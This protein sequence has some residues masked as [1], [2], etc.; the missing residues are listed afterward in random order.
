MIV[1]AIEAARDS[2]LFDR[3]VVS[4]DDEEIARVAEDCGAEAPFRRP[5]EL[6]NDQTPTLPVIQHAISAMGTAG[7]I[8]EHICCIYPCVPFLAPA[9]LQ[10]AH[11][12]LLAQRQ[13]KFVFPVVEFPSRIQ[14]A[15]LRKEGGEVAPAFEQFAMTRSQDLETSYYDAGQFYWG[16]R[17][18][19]NSDKPVHANAVTVVVPAWRAVDIDTPD[20]WA[21]AEILWRSMR[22]RPS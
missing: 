6:A 5:P 7:W 16:S 3:I 14:R 19:W 13:D 20:D 21:L 9:D 11:R 8:G 17:R 18:A 12:L 10:S 2:G 1:Y 4:T 15:L 22:G